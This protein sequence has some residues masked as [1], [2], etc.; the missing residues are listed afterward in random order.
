[1]HCLTFKNFFEP[2]IFFNFLFFLCQFVSQYAGLTFDLDLGYVQY[3]LWSQTSNG[4]IKCGQSIFLTLHTVPYLVTNKSRRYFHTV[5]AGRTSFVKFS[6][7]TDESNRKDR[8]PF[9]PPKLWAVWKFW[10]SGQNFQAAPV[11]GGRNFK[12]YLFALHIVS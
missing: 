9:L 3:F 12:F 7:Q 1:M 11:F 10:P 6:F 8:M 5:L 2:N 4:G